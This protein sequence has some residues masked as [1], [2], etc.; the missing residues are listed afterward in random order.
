MIALDVLE[1]AGF[2]LGAW[3]LARGVDRVYQRNAPT[4]PP[5]LELG[6][7]PALPAPRRPNGVS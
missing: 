2:G 5:D 3:L 4:P 7:T 6:P 1:L